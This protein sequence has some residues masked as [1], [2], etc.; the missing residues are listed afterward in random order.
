M[1]RGAK[2]AAAAALACALA[3]CGGS[4]SAGDGQRALDRFFARTVKGRAYAKRFPH[5]PGSV[6]CTARD[7]ELRRRV[8]ATCSTDVSLEPDRVVVTFTESWSHGN[9]SRTWFVFLRKDGSIVSVSRAGS[10]PG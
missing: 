5:Q 6:P 8:D 10:A 7:P 2:A 9:R 4:A 3:G 1:R